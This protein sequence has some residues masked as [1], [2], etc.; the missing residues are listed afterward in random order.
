MGCSEA[1]RQAREYGPEGYI[2]SSGRARAGR[3]RRRQR[4]LETPA[5]W[6]VSFLAAACVGLLGASAGGSGD[7]TAMLTVFA[8]LVAACAA[9][10][11]FAAVPLVA[12]T[13]WCFLDG[14][15]VHRH[16]QLGGRPGP[17]LLPLAVL[18]GAALLGRVLAAAARRRADQA[19]DEAV[20]E[21]NPLLRLTDRV[22]RR[23]RRLR[24]CLLALAA[25]GAV[26]AGATTWAGE[27]AAARE[28]VGGHEVR[29]TTL[30]AA[31]P[32]KQT[33]L[34]G[35]VVAYVTTPVGWQ[36]PPGVRHTGAASVPR[37]RAAG[38]AVEVWVDASGSPVTPPAGPADLALLTLLVGV[39]TMSAGAGLVLTGTWVARRRVDRRDFR[40]WGDEWEQ[41]EPVWS[42]R[43]RNH[44]VGGR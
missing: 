20:R 39:A 28:R 30:V 1:S 15:F 40:S 31:V 3:R 33:A 27:A 35:G 37:G 2:M 10:G 29:A 4:M 22:R 16:A 38:T 12:G 11:P 18:L 17:D 21:L 13:N 36:D 14:F 6:G 24:S 41:V 44:G 7:P 43:R 8:A 9:A 26:A 23:L 5:A 42:G 25:L 32:L 19:A 34:R